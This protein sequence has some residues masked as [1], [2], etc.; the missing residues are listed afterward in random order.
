MK[1]MHVERGAP[2]D[3]EML[4]GDQRTLSVRRQSLPCGMGDICGVVPLRH[5]PDEMGG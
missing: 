4:F 1:V 2:R 5:L 3:E